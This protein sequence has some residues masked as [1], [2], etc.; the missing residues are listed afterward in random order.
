MILKY[1][2]VGQIV[3]TH[4]IAGEMRVQPWCDSPEFLTKFKSFYF[5]NEGRDKADVLSCR[6]H[7]NVALLKLRGIDSIEK[8]EKLRG[9]VIFMEREEANIKKGEWFIQELC[10][11]DVFDADTKEPLGTLTDVSKTGANDV[12]HIKNEKGEYLI[13]AIKS[14]VVSVDVKAGRIE[15]RP[16]KG[17]FGE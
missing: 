11:C 4:G 13:P 10:G 6:A 12:W 15:L 1:L 8:A 7:K 14:I 17:I 3:G 9:K 5:D 2:E 16:I